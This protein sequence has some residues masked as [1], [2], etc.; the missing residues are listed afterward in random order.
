MVRPSALR[1]AA[2]NDVMRAAVYHG[3]DQVKVEE[4]PVPD[5]GP[6]EVL[7]R[8]KACGVCQSDIKK[9]HYGLHE[10]PRIYGHETAGVVERTGAGVTKWKPGDRVVFHHHYPCMNC[11][12]CRTENYSMCQVYK[13]VVSTAGFVPSGGGF[14]ELVKLPRHLADHAVIAMP[15]SISFEEATFVEPLNC[16]LKAVRKARVQAGDF[17]WVIGAGPMGLLFVMALKALGARPIVS[18]PLPERRERALKLGAAHALDPLAA[19]FAG[20][21]AEVSGGLGPDQAF[22]AVAQMKP[23]EQALR[24]V[25]KGGTVCVFS[26][27]PEEQRLGVDPNLIYG[28]EVD[29]I[30]SYSSS[31]AVQDL[32]AELVFSR[33]VP[34][35]ELISRTY[36]LTGLMD[37]INEALHPTPATCKLIVTPEG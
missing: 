9:I 25:R 18:D 1:E 20:E 6:G 31:A 32:A 13:D 3:K 21:L 22:L 30:G 33:R 11:R 15:D 19:G 4:V 23:L 24:L 36:P 26:E 37:A 10:G 5:V 35:R 7:V 28:R 2:L 8:V 34:V 29:L 17:S 14:A 12:Y 16:T 27:F